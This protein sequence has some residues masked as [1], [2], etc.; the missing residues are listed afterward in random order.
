MAESDILRSPLDY[1]LTS[2]VNYS[3]YEN[4]TIMPIYGQALFVFKGYYW[5]VHG[6]LAIGK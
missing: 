5:F 4:E 1:N 6:Y 3:Q 2:G